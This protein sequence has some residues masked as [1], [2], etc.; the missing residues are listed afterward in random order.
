MKEPFFHGNDN[1]DQLERITRVLG[2][3]ELFEYL[4]KYNIELD[5][6]YEG[7][8]GK[9]T[10]KQWTKFINNENKHLISNEALDLL[11]KML[12]YD[13]VKDLIKRNVLVLL[14]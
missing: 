12:A 2:T 14:G 7:I 5:Q 6:N 10:R 13:H 1:Y 8:L 4:E 11:S 9:H 3:S